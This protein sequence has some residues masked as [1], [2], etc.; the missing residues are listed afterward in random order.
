MNVY[1]VKEYRRLGVAKQLV[2]MSIEESKILNLAKI[3]LMATKDGYELYKSLGFDIKYP[4]MFLWYIQS[5][6]GR[7]IELHF[8]SIIYNILIYI[9]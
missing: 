1:T 5:N 4:N 2:S 3:E 7:K 9:K 6:H 8:I